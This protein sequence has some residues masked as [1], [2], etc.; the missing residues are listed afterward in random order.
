MGFVNQNY[1]LVTALTQ[2]G[3][4]YF[5]TKN[6]NKFN[7]KFFALSDSD[8]NYLVASSTTSPFVHNTLKI[9]YVPNLSGYNDSTI[10]CLRFIANGITQKYSIGGNDSDDCSVISEFINPFTNEL[11]CDKVEF[12]II[13]TFPDTL[14][15]DMINSLGILYPNNGLDADGNSVILFNQKD[16]IIVDLN[17]NTFLGL[18]TNTINDDYNPY[19]LESYSML[20]NNFNQS[21][22]YINNSNNLLNINNNIDNIY[23]Y[24][25]NEANKHISLGFNVNMDNYITLNNYGLND[26][27]E[28]KFSKNSYIDGLVNTLPSDIIIDDKT[29]KIKAYKATTVSIDN[30][31]VIDLGDINQ[32]IDPINNIGTIRLINGY[33]LNSESP[34]GLE[35][36]NVNIS[37]NSNDI[38]NLRF[39]QTN[40]NNMPLSFDI[41]EDIITPSNNDIKFGFD[42]NS[43]PYGSTINYNI[44][45][46]L[47]NPNKFVYIDTNNNQKILKLSYNKINGV[48]FNGSINN[49]STSFIY[50][51]RSD[52]SGAKNYFIIALTDLNV[53]VASTNIFNKDIDVSIEATIEQNGNTYLNASDLRLYIKP[54]KDPEV[55]NITGIEYDTIINDNAS[56]N[57]NGFYYKINNGDNISDNRLYSDQTDTILLNTGTGRDPNLFVDGVYKRYSNLVDSIDGTSLRKIERPVFL[58]TFPKPSDALLLQY[59]N[60]LPFNIKLKIKPSSDYEIINNDTIT[61]TVN[62]IISQPQLLEEF[63][64]GTNYNIPAGTIG[65]NSGQG[66]SYGSGGSGS[67][68]QFRPNTIQNTDTKTLNKQYNNLQFGIS[69]NDDVYDL[70][71]YI[72]GLVKYHYNKLTNPF[73]SNINFSANQNDIIKVVYSASSTRTDKNGY[74]SYNIY[75]T[76]NNPLYIPPTI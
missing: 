28:V 73:N 62:P 21:I 4:E 54:Y 75:G 36:F 5:L 48:Y 35:N 68:G 71:L 47:S 12:P 44:I 31:N 32:Y 11:S 24:T 27:M 46:G 70:T 22:V 49:Y 40:T 39:D 20:I 50:D 9:G 1:T 61:I 65:G 59:S 64:L 17:L 74:F 72:N 66:D 55:G 42:K 38:T 25:I 15:S 8:A 7:I 14:N 51:P 76:Y 52:Y 2:K 69:E 29:Y 53:N 34:N 67:G 23:K 3:R 33:I 19:G 58:F 56:Y 45:L 37:S 57:D 18:R 10:D 30:T 43:I 63:I 16:N 13:Y 41:G 60:K 26:L 6:K